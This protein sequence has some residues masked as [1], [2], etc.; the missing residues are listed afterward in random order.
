MSFTFITGGASSG[1]SGFAQELMRHQEDVLFVATG[2]ITDPEMA[3]RVRLHRRR[4]PPSWV[5]VE[6]PGD[7]IAA[8]GS[9]GKPPGGVIIDCLT[10]WVNNLLFEN[11]MDRT[12]VLRKAEKTAC[13]LRDHASRILVVSNELGMGIIPAEPE[14]REFR[15]IAGEVNQLFAACSEKAFFVVSGI[16]IRIK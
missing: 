9:S 14:S 11:G 15:R 3:A 4:R 7:L 1:K 16:P 2:R 13:F 8:V 10:F 12:A 6:E 5:T